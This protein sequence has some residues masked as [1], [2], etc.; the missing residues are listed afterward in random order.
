MTQ[1]EIDKELSEVVKFNT[2]SG[3]KVDRIYK[4]NRIIFNDLTSHCKKCPTIIRNVF[5]KLKNHY[6][7]INGN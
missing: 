2:V 5:N 6:K 4:L 3:E 7:A 1:Q